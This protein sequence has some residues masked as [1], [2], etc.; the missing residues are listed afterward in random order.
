MTLR[1]QVDALVFA[2][3]IGEKSDRLRREVAHQVACL[4][5]AVDEGRNKQRMENVVTDISADSSSDGKQ[6]QQQQHRR[7]L[8]CL[9]DE[10]FEMARSCAEDEGLW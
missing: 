1:G 4:G 3:G 2:G 6:Q 5:F 9:T 7:V 10:Q 8:V